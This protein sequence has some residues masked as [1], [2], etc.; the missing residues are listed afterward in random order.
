MILANVSE[1]L[2]KNK[3]TGMSWPEALNMATLGIT[4]I[5][6]FIPKGMKNIN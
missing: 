6:F 4:K 5:M 3:W 1:A 2:G